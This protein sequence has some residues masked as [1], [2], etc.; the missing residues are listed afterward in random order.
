[1]L[2][3]SELFS[4]CSERTLDRLLSGATLVRHPPGTVLCGMGDVPHEVFVIAHGTVSGVW[5]QADG[6]RQVNGVL[7]PGQCCA[8]VSTVDG[9][10][11]MLEH[12]ARTE[13][14]L[15][16]IPRAL[17]LEAETADPVVRRNALRTLC[18]RTR[19]LYASAAVA[20]LLPLRER[21]ARRLRQLARVSHPDAA[22]DAPMRLVLAQGELAEMLGV[23]RQSV[24]RV[25]RALEDEGV[26][27]LG[28][29]ALE[30]VDP[31]RLAQAA[32][33]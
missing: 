29:G 14:L 28:R 30:I 15:V 21:V 5:L 32:L 13:V 27:Q 26:L 23:T 16:R 11:A 24:N 20:V 8:V 18:H 19:S 33:P 3:T 1:M 10:P 7:G 25:L 31:V 6:L 4:G 12:R 2:A 9:G 22:D 17:W